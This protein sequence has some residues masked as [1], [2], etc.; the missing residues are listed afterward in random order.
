MQTSNVHWEYNFYQLIEGNNRVRQMNF[1]WQG[2]P[3]FWPQIRECP[4]LDC[5]HSS[6]RA[7]K[8]DQVGTYGRRYSLRYASHKP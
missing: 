2:I 4:F 5:H 6:L 7:L 1:L 3:E 8:D